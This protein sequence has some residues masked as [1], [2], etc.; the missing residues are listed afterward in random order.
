MPVLPERRRE[1]ISLRN[2]M[3]CPR[4]YWKALTSM[5]IVQSIDTPAPAAATY[6]EFL[7]LQEPARLH[8]KQASAG[9]GEEPWHAHTVRLFDH[10]NL[11]A[12]SHHNAAFTSIMRLNDV[13]KSAWDNHER[14]SSLR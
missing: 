4:R 1:V 14:G 3:L 11:I 2:D 7:V 10:T 5:T 6:C 12:S 8:S 9:C 13:A